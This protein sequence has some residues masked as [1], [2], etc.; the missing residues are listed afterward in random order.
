MDREKRMSEYQTARAE[1]QR[2]GN[3]AAVRDLD[4][5]MRDE[6]NKGKAAE[7][8]QQTRVSHERSQG[9]RSSGLGR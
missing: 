9:D 6:I 3:S 5:Q 7:T 4:N 1:A 2:L 8:K